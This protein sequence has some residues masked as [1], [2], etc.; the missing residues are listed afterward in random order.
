METEL[1]GE[2][3]GL[4]TESFGDPAATTVLGG[5][6]VDAAVTKVVKREVTS[7]WVGWSEPPSLLL[8]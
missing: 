5:L 7:H 6:D 2:D 1:F 4:D 3:D 8:V